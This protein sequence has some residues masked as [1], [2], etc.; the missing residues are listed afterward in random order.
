MRKFRF[1]VAF[2]NY[3]IIYNITAVDETDAWKQVAEKEHFDSRRTT[4]EE[5]K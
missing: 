1:T 4:I 2:L 3:N 5:V